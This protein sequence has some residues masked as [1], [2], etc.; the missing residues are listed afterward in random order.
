MFLLFI[1][2][3]PKSTLLNSII[4]A[5]DTS[6]FFSNKNLNQLLE[7]V[8]SELIK[9]H[10]WFQINKLSLNAKKTKYVIFHKQ[11]MN[12]ALIG[13]LPKLSINKT[14][15][16]RESS[17]NF[18]GVI[19]DEKLNWEN[20]I[21]SVETK[22]SK[23]IAILYK[24]SKYL[25]FKS[26]KQIYFSL[27]HSHISYANI[28]WA[29]T[30]KTKLNGI[31]LKQKHVACII[32]R[33]NQMCHSRPLLNEIGALNVYQIN[34]MQIT[35]FV[36]N[37]KLNLNPKIFSGYFTPV[38][39]AYSTRYSHLNFKLPS[40]VNAPT[41]SITLRGPKIW[42]HLLNDIEKQFQG[43]FKIKHVIKNKLLNSDNELYYY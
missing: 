10:K 3:F 9:I 18:L 33:Q 13:N 30:F 4:F 14:A 35:K 27:I 1:N 25:N 2:D 40:S 34:I 17:V 41:F 19:L 31:W 28:C 39:H 16:E 38:N 43:I 8:N 37:S 15:I 22:I 26:L 21:N 12:Q 11:K 7:F 36:F 20:Q 29:S 42:N 5:D 23:N 24:A 32:F 6:L